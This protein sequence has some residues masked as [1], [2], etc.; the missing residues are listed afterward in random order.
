MSGRCRCTAAWGR[1]PVSSARESV[2][3]RSERTL[4]VRVSAGVCFSEL[5]VIAGGTTARLLC[6][7]DTCRWIIREVW[8][9]FVVVLLAGGEGNPSLRKHYSMTISCIS[10]CHTSRPKRRRDAERCRLSGLRYPA[11][12]G[13]ATINNPLSLLQGGAVCCTTSGVHTGGSPWLY[14]S[15]AAQSATGLSRMRHSRFLSLSSLSPD[16]SGYRRSPLCFWD[17]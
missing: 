16:F 2:G 13:Q 15:V 11:T 14:P 17:L 4:V 7:F 12:A 9:C 5:G 10:S 8:L 1:N 3:G 6:S